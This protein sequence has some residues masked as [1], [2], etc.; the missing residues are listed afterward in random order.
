M[1][2]NGFYL[3][4]VRYLKYIAEKRWWAAAE[5][6]GVSTWNVVHSLID[7]LEFLSPESF[8]WGDAA[9]AGVVDSGVGC[10][11]AGCLPAYT[12]APELH[13]PGNESQIVSRH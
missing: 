11:I 4:I 9:A 13:A 12:V 8:M 3:S 2:L 1:T 7:F 6:H 10:W 5:L